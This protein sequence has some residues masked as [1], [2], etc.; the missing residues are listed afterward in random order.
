MVT[1]YIPDTIVLTLDRAP[2]ENVKPRFSSKTNPQ[3]EEQSAAQAA[4]GLAD[5]KQKQPFS[6]EEVS[7]AVDTLLTTP[8][9]KSLFKRTG[10]ID[11]FAIKREAP[12]TPL[13]GGTQPTILDL[14]KGT[15][16]QFGKSF[17]SGFSAG[18]GVKFDEFENK[19]SLRHDIELSYRLKNGVMFKTTQEL[20]GQRN[21]SF[22]F[23]KF[24]RFGTEP[25]KEAPRESNQEEKP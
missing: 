10:F 16:L 12:A 24:W 15:K 23:E 22:F 4:L 21:R 20:D 13:A 3:E 5:T 6:A 1:E 18:Y 8:F 14:Y 2:L 9:V 25:S 19:L 17:S 7:K 11:K